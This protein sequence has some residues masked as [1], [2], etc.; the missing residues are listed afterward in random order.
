MVQIYEMLKNSLL[1]LFSVILVS[2][3]NENSNIIETSYKDVLISKINRQECVISKRIKEV[4]N[5]NEAI[6][7][8]YFYKQDS[9]KFYS[10]FDRGILNKSFGKRI[11]CDY[12]EKDNLY[13]SVVYYVGEKYYRQINELHFN[14]G[15]AERSFCKLKD[16]L[17]KCSTDKNITQQLYNEFFDFMK[18]GLVFLLDEENETIIIIEYDIF[19]NPDNHK[20]ILQFIELN[21]NSFDGIIVTEGYPKIKILK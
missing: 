18:T 20:E 16:N 12:I 15:F 19:K 21:K 13:S 10:L 6:R 2:C 8:T 11:L 14:N 3:K 4:E 9:I 5:F 7:R 17:T 1:I